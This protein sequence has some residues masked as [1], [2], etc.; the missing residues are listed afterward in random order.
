[1]QHMLLIIKL[2]WWS[3]RT[4]INPKSRTG[5]HGALPSFIRSSPFVGLGGASHPSG[6][7]LKI[8]PKSLNITFNK[9]FAVLHATIHGY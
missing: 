6:S 7:S 1:M 4:E 2:K 3:S 5:D 8:G 9:G